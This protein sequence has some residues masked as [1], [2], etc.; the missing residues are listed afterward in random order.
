MSLVQRKYL[1][2]RTSGT[3]NL[4]SRNAFNQK[5]FVLISSN[6]Y[7][8]QYTTTF[9]RNNLFEEVQFGCTRSK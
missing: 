5:A 6:L 1:K 7:S 2:P 4:A 9:L 3:T 8:E